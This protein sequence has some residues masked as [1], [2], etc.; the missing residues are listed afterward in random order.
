MDK[1]LTNKYFC[2]AILIALAVVIYLYSQNKSCDIEGMQNVDLTPLAQEL[3]SGPWTDEPGSSTYGRVGT[4]FDKY[5]DKFS[6]ANLKRR[7]YKF[8]NF[9]LS[10]DADYLGYVSDSSGSDTLADTS[11]KSNRRRTNRSSRRIPRPFNDRPDLS[12]CQPCPPCERRKKIIISDSAT[13]TSTDSDSDPSP[14]KK[15]NVRISKKK[16]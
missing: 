4:K 14:K 16:N 11:A 10:S 6:K 8:T 15:Y 1:I 7:G 13:D 2:I 9:L 3:T 5:A 12:Q